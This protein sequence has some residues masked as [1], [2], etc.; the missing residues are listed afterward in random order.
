MYLSVTP[1]TY[2]RHFFVSLF[3]KRRPLVGGIHQWKGRLNIE[4]EKW[5]HKR[6]RPAGVQKGVAQ[7][8]YL[9]VAA[10]G[11]ADQYESQLLDQI[12]RTLMTRSF[13]IVYL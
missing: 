10:A 7:M 9:D 12:R 4:S 1:Q 13:R 8:W 5:N 11:G 3:R 6:M 2:P